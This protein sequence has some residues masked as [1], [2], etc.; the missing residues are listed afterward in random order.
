[1][2]DLG[3]MPWGFK[4]GALRRWDAEEIEA[5]IAGGCKSVRLKRGRQ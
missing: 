2:A 1:M 3:L 5:W 4:I